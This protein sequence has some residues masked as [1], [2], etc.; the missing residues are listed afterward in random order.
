MQDI[1]VVHYNRKKEKINIHSQE[2]Q[3]R[4]KEIVFYSINKALL[5]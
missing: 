5:R 3:K 4:I 2:N 1:E